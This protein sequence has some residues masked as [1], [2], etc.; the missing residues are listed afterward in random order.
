MCFDPGGGK[1]NF[2][3]FIFNN[4]VANIDSPKKFLMYP[5][6]LQALFDSELEGV[7]KP[8]EKPAQ[9]SGLSAKIFKILKAPSKSHSGKLTPVPAS[10]GQPALEGDIAATPPA[11]EPTPLT[12]T[13]PSTAKPTTS[14]TKKY[15]KKRTPAKS[16]K[17]K[18]APKSQ[19]PPKKVRLEDEIPVDPKKLDTFSTTAVKVPQTSQLQISTEPKSPHSESQHSDEISKR[20]TNII[21]EPSSEGTS[22]G[23]GPIPG[24]IDLNLSIPI[25]TST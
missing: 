24:S 12:S 11:D 4:L 2:S 8:A 18:Q 21:G 6:F 7:A 5:R 22:L 17:A 19:P 10:L 25:L 23:Q 3:K 9:L 16:I 15:S 13:L 1:Y 20:E 14:P